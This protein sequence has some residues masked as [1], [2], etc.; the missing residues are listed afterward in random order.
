MDEPGHL[1]E[2]LMYKTSWEY[3][4]I[5]GNN[6]FEHNPK[7]TVVSAQYIYE[8]A[9]AANKWFSLG[10]YMISPKAFDFN[11][12][13][14]IYNFL[15]KKVPMW[16]GSLPIIGVTS[17]IT[18]ISGILQSMFE[19]FFA[20]T[21]LSIINPGANNYIQIID[22][23]SAAPFDMK[24]GTFVY[25]S[26]EDIRGSLFNIAIHKYYNLPIVAKSFT[27]TAKEPDAHA[28]FESGVHTLAA[29]LGGARIFRE[30]GLL[31]T[32]KIY[33]AEKL[34]L[35]Y[36][37]VQYI[38]NLLRGEDFNEKRLMVEEIRSANHGEC[39]L[40]HESTLKNFKVE[41]WDPKLFLH[42]SFEQWKEQGEKSI[43]DY[44]NEI[45]KKLVNDHSYTL[46]QTIKKELDEIL[47]VA[48]QDKKLEDS[49]KKN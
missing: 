12:L 22:S 9:Q 38:K 44:A 13:D 31:A 2:I 42:T 25:G 47:E 14:I 28:A 37:I 4:G 24:Y 21:L 6:I 49:F 15:D 20:L 43:I 16:A 3:S 11:E 19:T 27:T 39:F 35:D 48:K 10:I 30:A 36:E 45:A 40:G 8:M 29:A 23:F 46:D 32:D 33:S 17:P 5:R 26:P 18:M 7:S 34:V 1:R 41:L